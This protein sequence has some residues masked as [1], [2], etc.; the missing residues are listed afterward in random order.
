[1]PKRNEKE[2]AGST[3]VV[4]QGTDDEKWEEL[5]DMKSTG[6]S[7]NKADEN[8]FDKMNSNFYL[9]DGEACDIALLEDVPH[10]FAGHN[11]KLRSKSGK[12]YYTVEACLKAVGDT[13]EMC[14]TN[15]KN[16]GAVR[17]NIA[18]VILDSRGAFDQKAGAFDGKPCPK[19][20]LA[21][22]PVAKAFKRLRDDAGGTLKDKVIR[23]SKD[24]KA[25]SANIATVKK[26]DQLMYKKA[27]VWTGPI[28]N[29]A[30]IYAPSDREQLAKFLNFVSVDDGT[31]EAS[32][33]GGSGVFGS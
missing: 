2:Q 31:E 4:A 17:Q 20:F 19:I 6:M 22:L 27:P 25:Y 12:T 32:G 30:V 7:M 8:G 11:L 5:M 28:P 24:A 3:P 9:L 33:N 15:Q 18:F 26:G 23:L 21:P 14:S 29:V 13:C 16:V 10:V 1:M